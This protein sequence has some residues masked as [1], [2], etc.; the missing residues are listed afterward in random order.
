MHLTLSHNVLLKAVDLIVRASDKN[1]RFV[2]LGNIKF[3]LTEERLVLTASDM[4]VELT[5]VIALPG[6]ACKQEGTITLPANKFHEICKSLPDGEV[7]IYAKDEASCRITL[8]KSRFT[9]PILPALD[10]PSIGT[11]GETA[12]T[13]VIKRSDLLDMIAHTK[14]CMA[15]NDVRYYLTGMLFHLKEQSLITVATDGHRLAMATRLLEDEKHQESDTQLIVPGKAVVELE[16][17][18]TELSKG[19]MQDTQ[20]QLWFD[21]EF[22]QVELS[23]DTDDQLMARMTARLIDGK[24]PD[25]RRV[26]PSST[27]RIAIFKKDIMLSSLRRVA[28]LA[29]ERTKGLVFHFR[30]TDQTGNVVIST[31]EKDGG[32]AKEDFDIHYEGEPIEIS[33][34]ELYI[35]SVLGVLQ[36]DIQLQMS[37]PNSPTLIT[38]VGDSLYQYV[39]MPMRI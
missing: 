12:D 10:F 32:D 28:I 15:N 11:M 36:G 23:F 37:D 35:K 30:H 9:L 33:L 8:G 24:F 21:G 19:G 2:I 39:V 14:F 34:N 26:L 1:H 7:T 18:L 31:G 20:M 27:D 16:R 4:E 25:Y 3:D 29:S 6:G 22:L 38:Q 13:L 5:A 17:L